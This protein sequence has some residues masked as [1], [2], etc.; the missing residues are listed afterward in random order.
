VT[1][2]FLRTLGLLVFLLLFIWI[3]VLG[4][5]L[6]HAQSVKRQEFD[7]TITEIPMYGGNAD[8]SYKF[9]GD[10]A[11]GISCAFHPIKNQSVC[12]VLSN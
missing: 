6:I 8:H 2:F 10:H 1:A 12:Y 9:P 5:P 11:V 3:W 4:G 7:A